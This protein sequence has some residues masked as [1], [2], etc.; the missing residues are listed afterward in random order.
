MKAAPD[1]ADKVEM[2]RYAAVAQ[3]RLGEAAYKTAYQKGRSLST[4]A[5]VELAQAR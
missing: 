3:S 2:D 1:P 5:A 4:T